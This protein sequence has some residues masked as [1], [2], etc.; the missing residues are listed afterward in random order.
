MS[1]AA[2]LQFSSDPAPEL[3]IVLPC[4][5]EAETLAICIRKAY[6][7]LREN[8]IFGEVIVADNGSTDGSPQIAVAGGAR[9]IHVDT[10]GYGAA[11]NEMVKAPAAPFVARNDGRT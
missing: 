10:R 8:G 6:A 11:L 3:T 4:L 1:R 5:D 7:V 2:T 9:V